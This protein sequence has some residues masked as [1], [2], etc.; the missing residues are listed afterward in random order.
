M[1]SWIHNSYRTVPRWISQNNAVVFIKLVMIYTLIRWRHCFYKHVECFYLILC[2]INYVSFRLFFAGNTQIFNDY[3]AEKNLTTLKLGETP[4]MTEENLQKFLRL[5]CS[6]VQIPHTNS[7]TFLDRECFRRKSEE[8][9]VIVYKN[10]NEQKTSLWRP[11]IDEKMTLPKFC[12]QPFKHENPTNFSS[13]S[14]YMKIKNVVSTNLD[15]YRNFRTGESTSSNK[16]F[17]Y[18]N[19]N[20]DFFRVKDSS[21]TLKPLLPINQIEKHNHEDQKSSLSPKWVSCYYYFS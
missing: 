1:R 13:Y 19:L 21:N 9:P 6:F 12:D 16:F 3:A 7:K 14:E 18:K 10:Q 11:A 2:N 5:S 8:N 20:E 4:L 17:K 15:S